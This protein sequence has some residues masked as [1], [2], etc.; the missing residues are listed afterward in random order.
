[1]HRAANSGLRSQAFKFQAQVLFGLCSVIR[2]LS[3]LP[4]VFCAFTA[5][6]LH[7]L[8]PLRN[9]QNVGLALPEFL[10]CQKDR[11]VGNWIPPNIIL[12]TGQQ[13]Q[14]TPPSSSLATNAVHNLLCLS[15][16]SATRRCA[17]SLDESNVIPRT[18]QEGSR[19][20]TAV[21]R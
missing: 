7:A 12:T 19:G 2:L 9:T 16:L 17:L 14:S 10:E 5:P 11:L 20:P 15:F 21:H 8:T 3:W 4:F 13:G 18:A 1:M 6:L